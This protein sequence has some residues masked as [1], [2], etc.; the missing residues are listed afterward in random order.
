[1]NA[2]DHAKKAAEAMAH[3]YVWGSV[4]DMMEGGST[5]GRQDATAQRA[6]DATINRAQRECQRLL[7]IYDRHMAA[8]ARQQGT[9][10]A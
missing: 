2:D 10:R 4:I 1:M 3:L 6:V 5:P 8:I 9:P 7:K